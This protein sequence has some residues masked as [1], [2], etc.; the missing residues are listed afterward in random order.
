VPGHAGPSPEDF[1]ERLHAVIRRYGAAQGV[2]PVV[3]VELVGGALFALES[4]S[5]EPGY[6]FVTLVVDPDAAGPEPP[7]LLVVPVGTIARIVVS[8][9]QDRRGRL[10]FSLPDPPPARA[11]P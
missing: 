1:V 2:E 3:E 6:G 11:T 8:T 4:I 10:G 9:A 7:E 5:A